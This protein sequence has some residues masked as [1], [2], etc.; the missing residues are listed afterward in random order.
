MTSHTYDKDFVSQLPENSHHANDFW[1]EKNEN[2]K[3]IIGNLSL[4]LKYQ[5]KPNNQSVLHHSDIEIT[6]LAYLTM[7]FHSI[8]YASAQIPRESWVEVIGLLIGKAFN[9]NTLNERILVE[10]AYPI[11]YGNA[12]YV[13]ISDYSIIPEILEREKFIVGWYHSHPS[14]GLF[15]SREDYQTQLRYQQH[16]NK[17][18]AIVIDP[19]LISSVNFGMDAF[20]LDE[21]LEYFADIHFSII[22]NFK[23]RPLPELAKIYF[24]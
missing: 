18:I 10:E 23:P 1:I 17:A 19:T 4:K 13:Q 22:Q 2:Y 9:N 3:E 5:L 15:M 21:K 24:Q 14:Y 6:P 16:W 11:G 7:V 20:R 8:K 12:T